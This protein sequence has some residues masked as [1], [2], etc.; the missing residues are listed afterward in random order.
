MFLSSFYIIIMKGKKGRHLVL[1]FQSSVH[2]SG[3]EKEGK[4]AGEREIEAD[5][6]ELTSVFLDIKSGYCI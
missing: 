1:V 5:F 2:P 3:S 6:A 4:G